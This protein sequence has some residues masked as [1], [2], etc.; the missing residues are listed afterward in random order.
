[1]SWVTQASLLL[2]VEDVVAGHSQ[3]D[4]KFV[5]RSLQS[6]TLLVAGILG[7]NVVVWGLKTSIR[8]VLFFQL[9]HKVSLY[10]MLNVLSVWWNT[11]FEHKNR[12]KTFYICP[13]IWWNS[14]SFSSQIR[15]HWWWS[16]V[17]CQN[18]FRA[19]KRNSSEEKQKRKRFPGLPWVVRE[20]NPITEAHFTTNHKINNRLR[21]ITMWGCYTTNW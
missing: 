6:C 17:R 2:E 20:M 7:Q 11:G 15:L 14:T 12:S 3:T 1:M 8:P 4:E 18:T 21:T 16:S 9:P 13:F 5:F 19:F 10:D